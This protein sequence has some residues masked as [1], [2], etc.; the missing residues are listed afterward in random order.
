MGVFEILHK[1]WVSLHM[2][3]CA[4]S[5]S[6]IFLCVTL[7]TGYRQLNGKTKYVGFVLNSLFMYQNKTARVYCRLLYQMLV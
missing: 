1:A 4:K 7:W 3:V 6:R 2:L 5:P